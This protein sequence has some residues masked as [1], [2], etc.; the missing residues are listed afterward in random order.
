MYQVVWLRL[1]MASFGVTTPLI[2]LIVSLFMAGLGIGSWATGRW[3]KRLDSASAGT[4]LRVYGVTELLIGLSAVLVPF[5]LI[6]AVFSRLTIVELNLPSSAGGPSNNENAFRIEVVVREEGMEITNGTARIA[7]I[8]KKDDEYDFQT[9]SDFMIELKRDYP[10]HDAASVLME[11]H[12]PYDYLIQVMDIVRSVELPVEDP[13]EGEP[14]Y[15]LYAL[16]SEISV[17]DAP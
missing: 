1:A 2:S 7:S 5:L 13:V 17:G 9:L 16:F 11:A 8:P 15:Q 12:I 3:V 6:T 14:E 4:M 10:D